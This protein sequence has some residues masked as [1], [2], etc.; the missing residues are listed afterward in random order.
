M[1][2]LDVAAQL[3]AGPVAQ[4][5]PD[6][7]D[8]GSGVLEEA[9]GVDGGFGFAHDVQIVGLPE[10]RAEPFEHEMLI[11]DQQDPGRLGWGRS[12]PPIL[13]VASRRCPSAA[14]ARRVS[15]R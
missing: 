9:P 4:V 6:E 7:G 2:R 3:E 14:G 8:M 15:R 11:I 10:D 5:E 13:A 1:V 12:H